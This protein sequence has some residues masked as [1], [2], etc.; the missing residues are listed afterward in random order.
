MRRLRYRL[1]GAGA[2][3]AAVAI[4]GAAPEVAQASAPASAQRQVT[5]M[6]QNLYLGADLTPLFTPG[7]NFA[8]AAATVLSHVKHVDFP[9]RAAKIAEEIAAYHP[10]L[11]GLQEVALW[12]VGPD[13]QH[14]GSYADYQQTLLGALAR[15]GLS[16]RVASAD[17]NF[18]LAVPLA[19]VVPGV[20]CAAFADHDVILAR[21]DLPV[22]QLELSHPQSAEFGSYPPLV[23]GVPNEMPV[24]VNVPGLGTQT[25]I[26]ER[27]WTSVDVKVRGKSFR[28]LDSHLEA[29]G[30]AANPALFRNIQAALLV[31]HVITPSPLPVIA[32]G[33]YNSNAAPVPDLAGAYGILTGGGLT[34]AWP[35]ARHD[36]DPGYT[37]G[38]SDDL[39]NI[40][41]RIDH[42]IDLVL[43]TGGPVHAVPHSGVTVG[44]ALPT[45]TIEQ[46]HA[47]MAYSAATGQ[48]LWPSDHAGVIA[49]LH[50]AKP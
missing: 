28:F 24:T 15:D 35:L 3:L 50:L 41:S 5:V 21:G 44:N 48:W 39:N 42:R 37:S 6:T 32:V 38:Q 36:G 46:A 29:Y 47:V 30:P 25:V 11:I 31:Q 27:G 17:L 43:F 40:P 13:C 19:G 26:I 23:P 1:L 49:T 10:D 45:A 14:L 22:S 7:V 34:D 18:H 2:V 33:D 20:G 12:Q 9:A 4:A 8:T 16:Y